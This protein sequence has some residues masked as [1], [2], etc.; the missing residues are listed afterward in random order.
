MPKL[1]KV[2]IE[3]RSVAEAVADSDRR[4]RHACWLMAHVLLEIHDEEP[5]GLAGFL[6]RHRAE[7]EAEAGERS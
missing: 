7:R 6:A 5:G 1:R 3:T 4:R 2:A